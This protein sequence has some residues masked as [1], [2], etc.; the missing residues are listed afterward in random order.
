MPS[1][2]TWNL[3][4]QGSPIMNPYRVHHKAFTLVEVLVVIAI[5]G[6]LVGLLLP[7]VQQARES[8][9]RSSCQNNLK[10]QGLGFH[11]YN[12]AFRRLPPGWK[13]TKTSG[14]NEYEVNPAWG[15]Y[16]LPFMEEVELA[17]TLD[18]NAGIYAD[19]FTTTKSGALSGATIS[20]HICPSDPDNRWVVME[21]KGKA[22]FNGG[23]RQLT[24]KRTNYVGNSGSEQFPN[25]ASN[26]GSLDLYNGALGQGNG[27]ELKHF[28]DGLSSTVLLSERPAFFDGSHRGECLGA[29]PFHV[30]GLNQ[31]N[32][33]T[34]GYVD[35]SFHARARIN[36]DASTLY[37]G[38]YN[39][40]C[41]RGVASHHQDGVN[42]VM[43]D[44]ATRFISDDIGQDNVLG[45]GTLWDRLCS[46]NDGQPIGEGF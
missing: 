14:D 44:G 21:R 19:T 12:D 42:V 15:A 6:V 4:L 46:R 1:P 18:V 11:S 34:R 30:S 23:F 36:W 35:V 45:V 9:R 8:A 13:R 25:N 3:P 33:W 41:V 28:T 10:Q 38:Q 7:A 24:H 16:L 32:H 37:S 29:S 31:T 5:I 22:Q 40:D 39:L 17:N 26:T 43:T 2:L 27:L 20:W